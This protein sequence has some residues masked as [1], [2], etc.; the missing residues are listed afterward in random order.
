M[1]DVVYKPITESTGQD[2]V[3]A[4]TKIPLSN[5]MILYGVR[6]SVVGNAT[7]TAGKTTVYTVPAGKIFLLLSAH[8]SAGNPGAGVFWS[9]LGVSEVPRVA[10]DLL[11]I[12]FEGSTGEVQISPAVP[13]LFRPGESFIVY[14]VN[15][16]SETVGGVVGYEMD[17]QIFYSSI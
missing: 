9:S 13:L 1:Q 17:A 12:A 8:L 10:T 6:V 4:R 3:Q 2:V 7:G 14:N 11:R 16:A 15:S 5:L